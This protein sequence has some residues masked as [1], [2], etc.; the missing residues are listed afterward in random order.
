MLR[1]P[2]GDWRDSQV[3]ANR[4]RSYWRK[5]GHEVE[6]WV[7]QVKNE[8]GAWYQIRSNLVGGLPR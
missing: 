8:T 2:L 1:D 5:R 3:L 4:I 7:E 6:V